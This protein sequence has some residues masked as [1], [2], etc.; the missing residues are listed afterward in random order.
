VAS[1]GQ[2]AVPD[3]ELLLLPH[4]DQQIDC[5]CAGLG[6]R[7]LVQGVLQGCQV[8]SC[9]LGSCHLVTPHRAVRWVIYTKQS[10]HVWLHFP[11]HGRNAGLVLMQC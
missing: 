5:C 11:V 8:Q 7:V 1:G 2:Q 9:V 4:C 6:G 3:E 10:A